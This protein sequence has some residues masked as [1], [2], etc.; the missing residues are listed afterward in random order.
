MLGIGGWFTEEDWAGG[1]FDEVVGGSRNSF[2]IGLHGKLL[3]VSWETVKIL[4]ESNK[5][6]MKFSD[7][8]DAYGE[9]KC[10]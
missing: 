9:T 2:A 7:R 4:V 3:E 6:S 8:G 1:V 5:I 10:V